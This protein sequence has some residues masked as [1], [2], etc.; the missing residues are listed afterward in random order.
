MR[1]VIV[2]D[3]TAISTLLAD[4]LTQRG[5][6][7]VG[8][9][10]SV[11]SGMTLVESTPCDCAIIDIDLLDAQA[12]P[13]IEHLEARRIP[14]VPITGLLLTDIDSPKLRAMPLLLK[15][16]DCHALVDAIDRAC[17]MPSSLT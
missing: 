8:T 3:D 12:L 9:A 14:C 5:D 11:A 2:E 7:I 17:G 4:V 13:L 1:L 6:A 16:F 15:P 10:K